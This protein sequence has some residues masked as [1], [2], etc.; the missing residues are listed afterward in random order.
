MIRILDLAASRR[1]VILPLAATCMWAGQVATRA[2]SPGDWQQLTH[3][4]AS[5]TTTPSV[6]VFFGPIML[7]LT[8]P[9]TYLSL[10]AGWIVM[11]GLSMG[12][13]AFT[14]RWVEDLGRQSP[15]GSEVVRER[16]VLVGGLIA[17]YALSE[18]A[19]SWGHP[20]DVFALACVV[21]ALRAVGRDQWLAG[22]LVMA[23]GIDFKSWAVLAL[24]LACACAGARLRGPVV[25]VCAVALTWLPFLL[26]HH[27]GPQTTP[28]Y[29]PVEPWSGADILGAVAGTSPTWP[30]DAQVAVALL[31]GGLA[32]LQ[33]WPE[34]VPAIAFAV[35][36]NLDPATWVYYGAGA[37]LG[38]FIWDATRPTRVPGART[39]AGCL[40]LFALPADLGTIDLSEAWTLG[41]KALLRLLV[42]LAVVAPLAWG[43]AAKNSSTS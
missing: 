35:R 37:I 2:E 26:L 31:L 4:A 27:G 3:A 30:R 1:Y 33:S 28:V 9:F 6:G 39:I 41:L 25:T 13:A 8:K 21:L 19:V 14:I 24:P 34:L 23:G 17:L 11:S 42:L 16:T 20:E 7:M 40:A 38:L 15:I 43:Y 12:V 5:I 36:I 22:A 29:P 18:P 10:T 32:V